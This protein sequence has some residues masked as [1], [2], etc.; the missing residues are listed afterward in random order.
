MAWV[1]FEAQKRQSAMEMGLAPQDASP[2]KED[3][4][5]VYC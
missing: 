5:A 3:F 1:R 2:T 4:Q